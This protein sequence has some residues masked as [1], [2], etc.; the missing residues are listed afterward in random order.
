MYPGEPERSSGDLSFPLFGFPVRI[1]PWFWLMT[2]L[3]GMRLRDLKELVAWVLAVF[4]AIL[5]HELGHALVMRSYGFRPWIT[6]YA[7]GGL[8][9][10]S[11]GGFH[12]AGRESSLAEVMISAAGPGAGFLLAFTVAVL[13]SVTGHKVSREMFAGF[14]PYPEV[15]ETGSSLLT[16]FINFLL[17]FSV[18]WG[19]VNLLPI[20]P[21]D[22]GHIAREIITRVHRRDGLRIS[23]VISLVTA[24]AVAVACLFRFGDVFLAMFFAY[25]AFISYTSLGSRW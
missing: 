17:W 9:S 22:G 2:A 24:A 4:V 14:F 12:R 25:L 20:Y 1:H 10:R 13:L 8:T 7:F 5:I 21:L 18:V 15:S 19:A 16:S 3:M 23:L 6:L 11:A